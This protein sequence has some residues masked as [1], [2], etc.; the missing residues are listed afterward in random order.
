MRWVWVSWSLQVDL[1]ARW[2]RPT[3]T[4]TY[5]LKVKVQPAYNDVPVAPNKKNV[6]RKL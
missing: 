3:L 1:L 6:H 2:R 5:V 4:P